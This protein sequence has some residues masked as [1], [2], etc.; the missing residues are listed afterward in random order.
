MLVQQFREV[1]TTIKNEFIKNGP[2]PEKRTCEH[3]RSKYNANAIWPYNICKECAGKKY[4]E[5]R[6]AWI[7]DVLGLSKDFVTFYPLVSPIDVSKYR[8][9]Q[10]AD[11]S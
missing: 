7:M 4:W 10:D 8:H 11:N 6:E 9:Q 2:A 1:A 5:H 3:C